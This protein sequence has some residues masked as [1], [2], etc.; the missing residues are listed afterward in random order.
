MKLTVVKTSDL[1]LLT[2]LNEE[3]QELHHELYPNV[4]KPFSFAEIIEAFEQMFESA[5]TEAFVLK[6]ND[7]NIGYAIVRT[8]KS[9][10]NAFKYEE[11]RVYLDQIMILKSH[12][13]RGLGK[14]L[15]E[16]VLNEYKKKGVGEIELDN[17]S[18]NLN[19]KDFFEQNGFELKKENRI[20][21]L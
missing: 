10:E 21:R 20:K 3:V 16:Y 17:W 18:D 15:L 14:H 8:L 7:S 5:P 19:A 1:K 4:F 9:P 6:E 2:N 13:G 11:T 12:Q